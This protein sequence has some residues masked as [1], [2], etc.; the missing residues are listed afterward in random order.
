MPDGEEPDRGQADPF[1]DLGATSPLCSLAELRARRSCRDAGA[2][3]HAY[4]VSNYGLD[5]QIDTGITK[6][7]SNIMAALQSVAALL[8]LGLVYSLKGVLLV[9]EWAF[10]LDLLGEALG[11]VRRALERLH[12]R[13]LGR[14]WFMAALAAAGLWAIWRGLVQGRVAQTFGGLG[15]SV[16]LMVGA[17][18]VVNRPAET[19]GSASQLANDAALG[20]M[21]AASAGSLD[22][23]EESL[24]DATERLFDA[25]ALRPWCA[26]QFGDVR[27]CT[28]AAGRGVTNA[29]LWLRY[30]TE[31]E[32]RE[33][34]YALTKGASGDLGVP[35]AG[36]T[37]TPNE[38]LPE[39]TRVLVREEPERVRMQ[40]QGS[41]FTRIALLALISVGLLGAVLL[42]LYLGM[43]LVL[44]GVLSLLLLLLA[45]AM[46]LIAALGDSGRATFLAWAWRLVGALAAKLVYA[47]LL[48][49]VVVA[50][51]ALAALPIGWFG[52]W[53][54]SACFWWGVLLKRDE[55]L[56]FIS[57][58]G[59]ERDRRG[60]FPG[61]ARLYYNARAAGAL[62]TAAGGAA[63]AGPRRAG[64]ALGMRAA[65][66]ADV[67][68]DAVAQVA[69]SELDRSAEGARAIEYADAR[70][71]LAHR[72]NLIRLKR[73]TDRGLESFDEA[74]VEMP[75]AGMPPPVPNERERRL[76]DERARIDR[77]LS[78][79][80]MRAAEQTVRQADSARGQTGS[81]TSERDRE[82]WRDQRRRDLAA[83]LASDHDRSLRSAAIDPHEYRAA[84]TAR[85]AELRERSAQAIERERAQLAALP[86]R[87]R[88][89]PPR[90]A[91]KKA[92]ATVAPD[93]LARA[94]SERAAAWREEV[95]VRR[96][97]Q[98]LYR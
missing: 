27:W 10:S 68:R 16:L 56:G 44:A 57:V 4:P 91:V 32:E 14:P 69:R 36:I 80:R 49:I 51:T 46:L 9:V 83:G 84:D 30:P 89:A 7:E 93:E 45:P 35:F 1:R 77:A 86:E 62:A 31:G 78:S 73:A 85:Q 65:R 21:G 13:V 50:A 61:V 88:Q 55:L 12:E 87:G 5:V 48:A 71:T 2:V 70:R 90:R 95:K 66:R 54:L 40:E 81:L 26:L 64:A 47:L 67:D 92:I 58:S 22:R 42:L 79:E 96:R 76:L 82:A 33:A 41:T 11:S 63:T 3:A 34:L 43:R 74:V 59:P 18:V 52:T 25:L 28:R 94:R 97:R 8:W 72:E 20:F 53:L 60:G 17:L 19:V 38:V 24:A 29:D 98:G 39:A 6:V 15:L 37:G 75:A 23:P